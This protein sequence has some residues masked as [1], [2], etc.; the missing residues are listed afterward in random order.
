[1]QLLKI[2][3]QIHLAI[4]EEDDVKKAIDIIQKERGVINR[5]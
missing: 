5:A 1:M 4:M 2:N 3:R